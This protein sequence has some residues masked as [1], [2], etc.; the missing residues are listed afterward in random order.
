M[1]CRISVLRLWAIASTVRALAVSVDTQS[2]CDSHDTWT[3]AGCYSDAEYGHRAGF[4]WQLSPNATSQ[5]YFPAYDGI[6]TVDTCQQGCRGHGF[7]FAA[8][9]NATNCFCATQILDLELTTSPA[10]CHVSE[11]NCEGNETAFCRS[12][13]ATDVY[14]D[15]SFNHSTSAS[16]AI[17]FDYLGC[18]YHAA[19]GPLYTEVEMPAPS[20]CAAYCGGLGY[21]YMGRSG[22]DIES[23]T[24]T[25][26]CG[27]EIQRGAEVED[28]YCNYFCNG[29][30]NARY[31]SYC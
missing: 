20:D 14:E 4:T 16:T 12:S 13:V 18:F 3:Y 22:Y 8:L 11:L 6:I 23:D 29:S 9:N 10:A 19:P 26:A 1:R 30:T 2:S 17:G 7:R 27:T 24:S 15:P 21:A 31:Y 28:T 25:C 5:N